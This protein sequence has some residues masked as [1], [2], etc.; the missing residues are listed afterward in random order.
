MKNLLVFIWANCITIVVQGQGLIVDFDRYEQVP[1]LSAL[2]DGSKSVNDADYTP[3]VDLRP[4]CPIP[5]KQG[6][7]NSCTG[8]AVGY[9]ALSI[10]RAVNENWNGMKDSINQH[11]FSALFIYNQVKKGITCNAGSDIIDAGKLL[12]E[13]G[14]LTS[15]YYDRFK[16]QCDRL[17]NSEELEMARPF[18]IKEFVT[19]FGKD[20]PEYTKVQMTKLSIAQLKP[21]VIGMEIRASLHE[22][23]RGDQYWFPG[24]GSQRH[25]GSHA[26]VVV[27]YDDGKEAFEI[28]NSWGTSWGNEGFFWIKYKD[29]AQL[30]FFAYQFSFQETLKLPFVVE[31]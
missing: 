31:V 30:T 19:L 26:M 11:A 29:F 18:K 8:W 13:K 12:M 7:V 9:G 5:Q 17:P 28:M 2:G 15:Q 23:K 10:L 21:V 14:N 25:E 22:L 24:V 1:R 27:G 20:D 3:K 4:Y 16:N 6:V